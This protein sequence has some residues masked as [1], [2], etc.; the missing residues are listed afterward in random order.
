MLIV[1]VPPPD[2][3]KGKLPTS[4]LLSEENVP[5][6]VPGPVT[7]PVVCPVAV[8]VAQDPPHE[9]PCTVSD[10]WSGEEVIPQLGVACVS[11]K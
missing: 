6:K 2:T 7:G 1:K 5:E 11:E 10:T 3:A 9:T 4:K 8:R